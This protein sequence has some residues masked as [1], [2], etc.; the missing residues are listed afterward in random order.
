MMI[1]ITRPQYFIPIHGEY[2]HLVR[3]ARLAREMG[4]PD[5]KVLI[6]EDGDVIIFDEIGGDR[7]GR[8]E[9]GQ[10]VVDGTCV[11]DSGD[12]VLSGAPPLGQRRRPHRRGQA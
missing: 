6:A 7:V 8:V 2:R 1:S 3:H 12:V 10:Q 4:V 5:E 11:A 9:T